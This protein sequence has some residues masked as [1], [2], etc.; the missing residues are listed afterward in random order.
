M[1][2]IPVFRKYDKMKQRELAH[3]A[4]PGPRAQRVTAT[5]ADHPEQRTLA[6]STQREHYQTLLGFGRSTTPASAGHVLAL[7]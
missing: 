1:L 6:S 2:A 3:L 7:C 4:A 5:T